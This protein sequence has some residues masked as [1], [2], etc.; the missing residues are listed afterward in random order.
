MRIYLEEE[1][2]WE[3]IDGVIFFAHCWFQTWWTGPILWSRRFKKYIKLIKIDECFFLSHR[4]SI[5]FA[6]WPCVLCKE[7]SKGN[8]LDFFRSKMF[9]RNEFVIKFHLLPKKEHFFI[10]NWIIPNLPLSFCSQC[11]R[12]RIL[13]WFSDQFEQFQ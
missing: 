11:E 12:V 13:S 9:F 5:L 1:S 10:A 2:E 7:S 3:R 4:R 8:E 6:Y